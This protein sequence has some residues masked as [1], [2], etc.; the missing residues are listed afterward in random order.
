VRPSTPE[1]LKFDKND[2]IFIIE[3]G[4]CNII[5]KYDNF[6]AKE[7]RKWDFF[8]ESELLKVIVSFSN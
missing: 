6:F 1:C 7:L 5:H 4:T 2:G 8:G 3:S